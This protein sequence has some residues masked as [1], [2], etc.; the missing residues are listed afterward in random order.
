MKKH[1]VIFL[2]ICIPKLCNNYRYN[3]YIFLFKDQY[4]SLD[5]LLCLTL[6]EIKSTSSF[7]SGSIFD[8]YSNILITGYHAEYSI[9]CDEYFVIFQN[10]DKLRCSAIIKLNAMLMTLAR[11]MTLKF[12]YSSIFRCSILYQF[13]D[14][15]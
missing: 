9:S 13:F 12:L 8:T 15:S 11:L 5:N 10:V 4:F 7:D 2:A 6:I 14:S 1:N 3:D